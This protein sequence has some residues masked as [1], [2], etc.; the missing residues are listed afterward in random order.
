MRLTKLVAAVIGVPMVIGSFALAVGG[1]VALAVPDDDG[2]IST[3][4]VRLTTDAVALLGEDIEIDLGDHF[5]DGR[6]FI[7]WEAIPAKLEAES[8]TDKDV[9]VGI[10]RNADAQAYLDGVSTAR[11]ASFDDDPNIRYRDGADSIAPPETRD[12]WMASSIDGGLEWDVGD[13]EWAI[14]VLNTDG[15]AGVD[16]SLT[17]SA[18]IPFLTGI[19]VVLIAV[20]L[21]GMTFGSLLTYYGVRRVR[22]RHSDD[23]TP[24]PSQPVVAG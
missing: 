19:G 6:T 2:W 17:G 15:S 20:G 3:P 1:G 10:A 11:V 9:F 16:V 8:R 7:G 13:G 18:R 5:D 22:E 12:I 24:S 23:S 14:V 4:P 21:I